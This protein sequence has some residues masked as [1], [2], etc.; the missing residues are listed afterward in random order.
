MSGKAFMKLRH[1][2]LKFLGKLFTPPHFMSDKMTGVRLDPYFTP[3]EISLN[4]YLFR[5][6][7]CIIGFME[8]ACFC[9]LCLPGVRQGKVQLQD[10]ASY[11]H[12]Y[13]TLVPSWYQTRNTSA[14][15]CWQLLEKIRPSL[16]SNGSI[17]CKVSDPDVKF[18]CQ[19]TQL[20]YREQ[21]KWLNFIMSLSMLKYCFCI[22]YNFL[23]I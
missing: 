1:L 9:P 18:I 8:G 14:A 22:S 23:K 16:I 12:P 3:T 7:H 20:I 2:I 5:H 19:C 15:G 10:S 11:S 21:S 6:W 4:Q 13:T 17:Q